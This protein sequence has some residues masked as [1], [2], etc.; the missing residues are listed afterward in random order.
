MLYWELIDL[1]RSPEVIKKLTGSYSQ[2]MAAKRKKYLQEAEK[3]V[4]DK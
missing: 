1:L 4:L 2:A 3:Q